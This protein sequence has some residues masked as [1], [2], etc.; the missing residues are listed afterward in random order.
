MSSLRQT[1]LTTLFLVFSLNLSAQSSVALF[2]C[3]DQKNI[4]TLSLND[5]GRQVEG[6]VCAQIVV[7]ALHFDA[8]FGKTIT[9]SAG[10]NPT[11]I[12]P[13][14]F[15]VG[16]GT[17]SKAAESLEEHF[18]NDVKTINA[19][20]GSLLVA[21]ATNHTTGAEID[22][23]LTKLRGEIN[24]TDQI[25]KTGT[26]KSVTDF[27][28]GT[29][30][31]SE[32]D[33]KISDAANWKTTDAIL[34]QFQRLQ[35]DLNSLPLLFPSNT[36]AISGDPCS[37]SNRL[38]LGWTDWDKCRDTQFKSAQSSVAAAITEATPWTSDG[39]KAAQFAKK[40]GIIQYWKIATTTLTVD[41]FT[42]QAEVRCSVLFNKN[43]QTI[44]RLIMVDKT[45]IF[46]GQGG[47]PQIKDGLLTVTCT[48]PFAISAGAAFSTIQN[49]TFAIVQSV[50]A[51]GTTS[52]KTFGVTSDTRVNPYPIGIAHARLRDW[53]DNRY[54][55]HFSFGVGANVKSDNSGGS[56]AEFLT[57][58]SLSFLRTVFVTGGLDIGKQSKLE[59]GFKLGDTVPTDVTSPPVSSSYKAGF[60]FAITFT[61]P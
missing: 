13:S 46:D 53:A 26:P 7:N 28:Q 25:L 22:Q 40:V 42:L 18:N 11:S 3:H 45:G 6:P 8:D 55:V 15:S 19:L 58:L 33:Q 57:G 37:D 54:A 31:Q 2:R 36:G 10:A 44:L 48:S 23:Y 60:G 9:I 56:S 5:T 4:M 24:Q 59:G 1:F 32:L 29:A 27:V 39:D 35:A 16:S 43:E 50:P 51:S 21:E 12:F 47:Q 34:T 38:L 61:K 20:Q 30:F 17:P 52:V 49:R 14:S 41:S